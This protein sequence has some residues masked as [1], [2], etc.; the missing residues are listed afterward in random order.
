MKNFSDLFEELDSSTGTN[1]KVNALSNFFQNN[2]TG[3]SIYVVSFLIGRKPKQII[4]TAFL[5]EWARES[6][7]IDEWLFKES[8]DIVGDLAETISLIVPQKKTGKENYPVSLKEWIEDIILPLKKKS[9]AEQKKIVQGIWGYLSR[10]EKF[11]F[12]K[13]IT[14]WSFREDSYKSVGAVFRYY[15]G[16]YYP[17]AY[18]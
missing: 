9:E 2:S 4:K 8:Y 6:A 10:E 12:N 11:I 7:G 17:P 3:D 13:V 16:R 14:G 15:R 1:D 5:R 18:G